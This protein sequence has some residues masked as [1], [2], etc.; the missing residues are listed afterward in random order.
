MRVE[1]EDRRRRGDLP[2]E[3]ERA[4]RVGHR[5]RP[6]A[7]RGDHV[8]GEDQ[9][10][11]AEDEGADRDDQVP[12][13]ELVGVVVDAARHALHADDVHR[14]EGQVEEDEGHPEVQAA[15]ALVV[16]PARHL[17]EPVV[18]AG[19]DR[20]QRSA[21]E[22]V[23]D[24]GDDEVGV[25]DVD[26]QRDHRQHH[27]GDPAAGEHRQEAQGE[28]HR[29]VE[30]QHAAPQRRQPREDLDPGGDGDDRRGDHHRHADPRLH[31]RDEHVV[32]P[33]G[34]ARARRWP[35]ARRPSSGSRRSACG[36]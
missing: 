4:P 25:A 22:H 20:E 31:A 14:P 35:A 26:G 15:Q 2:L 9:R 19:E 10:A 34:E 36:P 3:R 18:D 27:A 21:E 17:R 13:R 6:A 7:P 8:V 23:V 1:V 33:H 29:R 12:G 32:R 24:V 16:H 11:Q 30:V 28:E 5:A